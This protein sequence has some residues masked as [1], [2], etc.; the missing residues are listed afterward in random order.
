MTKTKKELAKEVSKASGFT[1][2]E[3]GII[4]DLLLETISNSLASRDRIELRRFGVF[5]VKHRRP[6]LAR[7]PRTGEPVKLP[8]KLVCAFKP[9]KFVNE[10]LEKHGLH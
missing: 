5:S 3:A 6:R 10:K 8:A 1:Q 9:S 4:I 7:N 2:R